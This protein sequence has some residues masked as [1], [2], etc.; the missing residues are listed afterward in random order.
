LED[1]TLALSTL[2]NLDFRGTSIERAGGEESDRRQGREQMI[3]EFWTLIHRTYEGSIPAG[4]IFLPSERLSK[5]GFGWAPSTWMSSKDEDHP[6][7]LTMVSQATELHQ[8]GLLVHYPGFLLHGGDPRLV[9]AA[10]YSGERK[11]EF[12]VDRYLTEWYTATVIPEDEEDE[13]IRHQ[14]RDQTP[15]ARDII[16]NLNKN[17]APYFGI[18]LSRPKPRESPPEIGLLVEVYREIW[19]RKEPERVNKKIY[20]CQIIRRVQVSRIASPS[21]NKFSLPSGNPNEPPIGELM[22]EDSMWCVD[23]YQNIKDR[24]QLLRSSTQ[25]P[26]VNDSVPL[27]PQNILDAVTS[28]SS[29]RRAVKSQSV[30]TVEPE[31]LVEELPSKPISMAATNGSVTAQMEATHSGQPKAYE[32][33]DQH[34]NPGQKSLFTLPTWLLS[35]ARI[36]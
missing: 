7:P 20:C 4:L 36:M 13:Q 14:T 8:E 22:P 3:Q 31:R 32:Q 34:G 15:A 1:E 27:P 11:V 12:P 2:L 29:T 10:N 9:L 18:I 19:R 33:G 25:Q 17:K 5:V 24:E 21:H 26:R 35:K 28:P 6:H 16:T 30:I 23:G